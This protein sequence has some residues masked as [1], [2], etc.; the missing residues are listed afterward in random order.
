MSPTE[1]WR[2]W[3]SWVW[4]RVV[5]SLT[6]VLILAGGSSSL[7]ACDDGTAVPDPDDNAGLVADCKVLLTLRDELAGDG[8][9]NW[10][11]GLAMKR[12]EGVMVS[13]SPSRVTRLFSSHS[14]LT[15]VI[16]AALFSSS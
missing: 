2:E 9:L 6:A 7:L 10:N 8:S 13:G 16:P 14:Q 4:A 5:W 3:V 15:G 1:I 12:W 11:A